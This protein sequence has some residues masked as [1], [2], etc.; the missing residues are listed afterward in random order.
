MPRGAAARQGLT[1]ANDSKAHQGP[2]SADPGQV[3]LCK[4]ERSTRKEG[5][6][7]DR[8]QVGFARVVSDE[9]FHAYIFDLFV[10]EGYRG[11]GMAKAWMD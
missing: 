5:A 10:I 6:I 3:F 7:R 2:R 11:R 4:T 8:R 1:L 9:V